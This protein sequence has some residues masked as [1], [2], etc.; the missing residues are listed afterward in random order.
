MT[1]RQQRGFTVIE[2]LVVVAIV[3]IVAAIATPELLRARIAG[4]EA[5]AIASLR[6]IH[7]GQSTYASSCAKGGYAQSLG[8]LAKPP[9]GGSTGFISPDIA[10]N[11]VVKSGYILNVAPGTVTDVVTSSSS[12]CNAPSDDALSS[13]FA[14]AHPASI[15]S[16]GQRSFGMDHRGTIFQEL[17]G[18][19]LTPA[20]PASATPVQ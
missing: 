12:V 20:M 17:S 3:G 2:L 15:G 19:T 9:S 14:E 7:S 13:Y 5:S 1:L 4:N 11:G 18:A 6:A 16:S 8:D 10:T